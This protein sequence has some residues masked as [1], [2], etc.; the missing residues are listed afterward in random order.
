MAKTSLEI[1]GTGFPTK[2]QIGKACITE[3][4]LMPSL[5]FWAVFGQHSMSELGMMLSFCAQRGWPVI[6]KNVPGWKCRTMVQVG[7][8][9]A[10]AN[11]LNCPELV[12][13]LGQAIVEEKYRVMS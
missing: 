7:E 5:D 2:E 1:W 8:S 3:I 6:V 10:T 13:L 11:E 9:V 4:L 12:F